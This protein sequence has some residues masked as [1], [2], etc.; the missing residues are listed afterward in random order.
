LI[1]YQRER[2]WDL[3]EEILPL[4]FMHWREIAKY[5]DIRLNPEV[6]LYNKMDQDGMFVAYTA[7]KDGDLIGYAAYF[8]RHNMHYRDS[9]QAVQDVV[10][11]HPEFRQ[12]FAG[13]RL[14]K[15]ADEELTKLGVQLVMHHVKIRN[16]FSPILER[17][18]YQPIETIWGRRLDHGN[19]SSH[20]GGD[21]GRGA[22]W[23]Q[24][25][26]EGQRAD[27]GTGTSADDDG[28]KRDGRS[29]QGGGSQEK[30]AA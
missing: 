19:D 6:A 5:R 21:R 22:C 24:N 20:R 16:D 18:G 17:M 8:V 1:T 25:D 28:A 4:L 13:I 27:P 30:S 3:W 12:G 15:F 29:G 2:V 26:E 23:K 9:L 10:Y 7:R 11:L 14:L